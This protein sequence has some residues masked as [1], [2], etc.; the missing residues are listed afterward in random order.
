M[1]YSLLSA[2][3]FLDFKGMRGWTIGLGKIERGKMVKIGY[4]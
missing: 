3:R 2:Y 4:A 1:K